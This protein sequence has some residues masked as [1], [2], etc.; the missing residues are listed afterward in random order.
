MF[1]EE[2]RA[3]AKVVTQFCPAKSCHVVPVDVNETIARSETEFWLLRLA[4]AIVP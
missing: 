1:V 4:T 2:V 3:V